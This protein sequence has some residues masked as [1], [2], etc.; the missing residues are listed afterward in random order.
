[1]KVP[2]STHSFQ[3]LLSAGE[4]TQFECVAKAAEMG[5]DAI[6]FVDILP[7]DGSSRE[8]YAKKLRAE[9][10]RLGLAISNYTVS[11]DFING[12][13][14]DLEKEIKRVKGEID[15]AAILGAPGV[16]H[17]ATWGFGNGRYQGFDKVLP[18]LAEGCRCVTE[19]AAT[20]GIRTMVENHGL[21]C[22]DSRRVEKLVLAVDHENFGLLCDM[23]NFLC[24]DEDPTQAI[25]RTAPY[26]FY[27]HA[28]D[29][30]VKSGSGPNPGKGFFKTRGGNYL[31]GTIVG[32]GAVPV[33]QC[34]SILKA[35][36]YDGMV[37]IEFEGMEDVLEGISIGLENLR[38]YIGE[39]E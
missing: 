19:Y 1:M 7:H 17:D 13:D 33:R 23:G 11:A 14:G 4:I 12:C 35:A 20:L 15:I 6:E 24:V 39:T 32:H 37:A 10:E 26:A 34:I 28:K 21:F 25:S 18:R 27:A 2:V 36:G 9:C 22:Q 16:R 38:R 31:R 5:F 30:L 8:E 29:F 3:R